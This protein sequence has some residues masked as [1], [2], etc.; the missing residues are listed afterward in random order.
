[1]QTSDVRYSK[2]TASYKHISVT[3]QNTFQKINTE[4]GKYIRCF[5]I[6]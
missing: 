4:I 5:K 6:G 1:M 3:L 2:T